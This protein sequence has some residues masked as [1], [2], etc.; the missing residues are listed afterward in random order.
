MA[1]F[2]NCVEMFCNYVEIIS[3]YEEIITITVMCVGKKGVIWVKWVTRP[4]LQLCAYNYTY[5]LLTQVSRHTDRLSVP[6]HASSTRQNNGAWEARG[7]RALW[8]NTAP[9]GHGGDIPLRDNIDTVLCP[10]H[11]IFEGHFR[12]SVQTMLTATC[13]LFVQ[14]LTLGWK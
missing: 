5:V 8:S 3:S 6:L 11:C 14:M 1:I 10:S 13:A 2:T 9:I 7:A 12:E 4:Y